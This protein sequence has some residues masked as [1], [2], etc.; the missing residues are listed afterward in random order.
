MIES[1][2][3]FILGAGAS[4]PFGYPIGLELR[5][6]ICDNLGDPNL[7]GFKNNKLRFKLLEE[8]GFNSSKI[9]T[10]REE[11]RVSTMNSIDAF[12][13]HRPGFIKIGKIAIADALMPYEKEEARLF[14]VENNW[15]AYI[16]NRIR[17]D[18]NGFIN[19][20]IAFIT[21]N[22]DRSLEYYLYRA[23]SSAY[24]KEP[25]DVLKVL[26]NIPILH[27]YGQLNYLPWQRSQ[28][29]GRAYGS[30]SSADELQ[31]SAEKISIVSEGVDIDKVPE[32]KKAH[33]L[34]AN[35]IN[36][37]FLGFGYDE[38]NLNR[39]N[40]LRNVKGGASIYGTAYGL[41]R[42]EL[43]AIRKY[44]ESKGILLGNE[45]MDALAVLRHH[46]ITYMKYR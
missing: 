10:F 19:N 38:T 41:Q 18:F 28:E 27:L 42:A 31:K 3:V 29:D 22:Y 37:Y 17:T 14:D 20:K 45:T 11:F 9:L 33:E 30:Y 43:E 23:L 2:T 4:K 13:E 25:A 36:I 12:L 1:N 15:Y 35:A 26:E 16:F 6:I 46:M 32:F 5:K 40:I 34:L 44:F 39:L 24:G 8:L 7:R 21:F